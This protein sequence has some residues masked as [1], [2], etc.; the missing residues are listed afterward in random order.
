MRPRLRAGTSSLAA[1]ALVALYL[2]PLY[3]MMI[4]G[5]KTQGEIFADPPSFFPRAPTL[6]AFRYV[7]GHEN[8]ARYIRNSIAIALPVTL[9]TVTLS[10]MGA[11]AMSRIRSRIVDAALV[12]VLLLQVFPEALLATP[13]FIIF[14]ALNLLNTML[15]SGIKILVFS[16]TCAVYGMPSV[17]PIAEDTPRQPVN[18]YGVSKHIFEQAMEAYSV[19]YDLR[20]ASLRYF[21]AA[22]ADESGEIGELHLP[23]N[24]L[25]PVAFQ[26]ALGMSPEL[27]VF[28][29]DYPTPDGT[30][31]RD[32]I[33]VNDLAEAHVLALRQL[34]DG[35]AP[36]TL[37]LGTGQGNSVKEV[38]AAVERV[39]GLKVPLRM[40]PRRAGDPPALVANPAKAEQQL[41]WKTTRSLDETVATAWQ[42]M[43]NARAAGRYSS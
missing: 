36:I 5:F 6:D 29:E 11:Y 18:P 20:Y 9:V 24:H 7:I 15:D 40:G 31:V 28:G 34:Y 13:V 30:C 42:W 14:K 3:W 32:Y 25:I 21:N 35:A 1:G 38:I 41:H 17:I 39:S 8:M 23:E 16:S 33:H 4:S 22:G 27:H 26:A 2:F 12:T 10:A 19:A 37:N 43:Q